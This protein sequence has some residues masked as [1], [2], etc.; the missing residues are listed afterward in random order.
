V[1][2]LF[3]STL[4][5]SDSKISSQAQAVS[6]FP[7]TALLVVAI[8]FFLVH[9]SFPI[10]K[11]PRRRRQFVNFHTALLMIATGAHTQ[12]KSRFSISIPPC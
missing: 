7:F 9:C 8:S 2:K 3:S 10:S 5:F 6:Q 1:Q 4:F 12:A 11:F